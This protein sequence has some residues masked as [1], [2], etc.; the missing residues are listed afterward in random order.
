[1]DNSVFNGALN[2]VFTTQYNAS[3]TI[4]IDQTDQSTG[5]SVQVYSGKG[6]KVTVPVVDQSTAT[7]GCPSPPV[8]LAPFHGTMLAWLWN[9]GCAMASISPA[10]AGGNVNQNEKIVGWTQF[11]ITQVIYHGAC[12]V[13][14]PND[15]VNNSRWPGPPNCSNGNPSISNNDNGIFGYYKCELSTSPG[16][17]GAVAALGKPKLV[18]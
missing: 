14:N 12:V 3:S 13:D 15:Q 5:Q 1:M 16:S 6:W 18:K 9:K 11:V 10:F 17:P 2:D 8:T 4:T 7:G